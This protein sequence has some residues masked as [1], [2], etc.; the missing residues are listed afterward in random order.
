M[1]KATQITSDLRGFYYMYCYIIIPLQSIFD[2]LSILFSTLHFSYLIQSR[3]ELILISDHLSSP[4]SSAENDDFQDKYQ[5]QD[6][7]S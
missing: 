7:L 1:I 4:A 3:N 2:V 6:L 5:H